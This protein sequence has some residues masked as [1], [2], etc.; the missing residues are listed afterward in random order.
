MQ[1][2]L[3]SLLIQFYWKPRT[4]VANTKDNVKN[5]LAAFNSHQWVDFSR[6]IKGFKWRI[7]CTMW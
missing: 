7:F 4:A 2:Y 6:R 1:T 3:V 5:K